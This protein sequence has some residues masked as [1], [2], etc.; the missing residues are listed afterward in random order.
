MILVFHIFVILKHCSPQGGT[1]QRGKAEKSRR[2]KVR[3]LCIA[4]RK[5]DYQILNL[6]HNRTNQ[7]LL[8]TI[9]LAQQAQEE[10]LA[11][12]TNL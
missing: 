9:T 5:T 8:K 7:R 12:S 10:A 4:T 1:G 11:D 6:P 3:D 2:S